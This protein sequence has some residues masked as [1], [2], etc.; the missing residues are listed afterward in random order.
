M[1][2][3]DSFSGCGIGNQKRYPFPEDYYSEEGKNSLRQK[4]QTLLI[5]LFGETNT[6]HL[7]LLSVQTGP[8]YFTYDGSCSY[9]YIESTLLH[10]ADYLDMSIPNP[11]EVM[12]YITRHPGICDAVLY[13]CLL[14]CEEFIKDSEV[15]LEL[16][17]D[18]ESQDKY[19]TLYIR[20]ENY[21]DD[22]IEKMDII[23]DEFEGELAGQSGWLL[24]TTDYKPPQNRV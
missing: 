19:L 4:L 20:Q 1:L 11:G 24:L 17:Y 2:Y 8:G 21:A 3:S 18:D 12:D 10:L 16:Y 23:C 14:A 13:A 15:S 5:E 6:E 22:I 9:T 7:N